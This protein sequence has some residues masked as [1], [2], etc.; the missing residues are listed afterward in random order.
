MPTTRT[1]KILYS[2][3]ISACARETE[4]SQDNFANDFQ[5]SY[6]GKKQSIRRDTRQTLRQQVDIVKVKRVR[7]LES[8]N[9]ICYTCASETQNNPKGE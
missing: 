4:Q 6:A 9:N 5:L 2:Y 8:K 3:K 7:L 1:V